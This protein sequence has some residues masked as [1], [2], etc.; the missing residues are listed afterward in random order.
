MTD[1][2]IERRMFR[3]LA[4][5]LEY[6]QPGL[7]EAAR[8]CQALVSPMCPEAATLLHRFC[9]CVEEAPPGHMEEVYTAT[10]DLDAVCQPYVGYHLFGETYKR[11]LFLLGLKQRYQAHGFVAEIEL[12]DHVGVMLHFLEVCD[13]AAMAEELVE[14]AL[15]PALERMI[16]KGQK[17][18]VGTKGDEPHA[19]PT[20]RM[21]YA[22]PLQ[23]VRLVLQQRQR[24][25]KTQRR[26]RVQSLVGQ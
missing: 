20:E 24:T 23:A 1:Q 2:A 22:L 12:P 8:E 16:G 3:C 15:L 19:R 18:Q 14:E 7:V 4:Q 11:S 17:E 13:D 9:A 10:F 6:P 21:V 5:M 25:I 26:N